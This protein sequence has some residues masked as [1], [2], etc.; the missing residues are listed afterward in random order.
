MDYLSHTER[1]VA[2]RFPAAD[3]AVLAGS[4]ARGERTATSDIDLLL[5]GG[6][7]FD[8]DAATSLAATYGFDGEAFEVFAYTPAGFE[9]WAMRGIAQH[10]PVIAHMLVDGLMFR[11]GADGQALRETWADRLAAGPVI[12]VQEVE[13]RRYHLTDA[14]DDLRDATDPLERQHLAATVFDKTAE[15]MLLSAGQWIA[16]GKRLPRHLRALDDARA[17]ALAAPYLAGRL[18]EFADVA[19][20]ELERAG[21]RLRIGY[22]R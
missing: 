13:S 5:I 20:R 16:S 9:T 15:L 21:G 8:G 19:E 18:D 11:S 7:L 12:S 6:H 17:T 3:I 1:F 2:E 14:I 4:T 22:R 10:R